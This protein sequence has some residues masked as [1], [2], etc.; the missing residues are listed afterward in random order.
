MARQD[1][2]VYGPDGKRYC[3]WCGTRVAQDAEICFL[4]GGSLHSRPRRWHIPWAEIVILVIVAVLV[5]SWWRAE[6]VA[7]AAQATA[8]AARQGTVTAVA[9]TP[10]R[11]PTPTATATPTATHTP[12]STPTAT[13]ELYTVTSGDTLIAIAAEHGVTVERLAAFNN[14]DVGALLQV[15]Q[16]LLIPPPEDTPMPT[17]TPTLR[18]ALLNYVVQEGDTLYLIAERFRVPQ[19]AIL[20]A[21]PGINPTL[22]KPGTG[23]V[24]PVGTPEPTATPTPILTPTPTPGYPYPAP[25]IVTPADGAVFTG[26]DARVVLGWTAAGYLQAGEVYRVRLN[27]D[28][29]PSWTFDT[30]DTSLVLPPD[31]YDTVQNHGGQVRWSVRVVNTRVAPGQPRSDPSPWRTFIWRET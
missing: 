20:K 4:C 30:P 28:N 5:G 25:H 19:D 10:T 1:Y 8:R 14:L 27:M 17:P 22:I 21:N 2:A 26:P 7:R 3:P 15:D 9:R 11:T 31:L 6:D 13:P 18:A 23:L 16:V 24:I 29:G 12:T